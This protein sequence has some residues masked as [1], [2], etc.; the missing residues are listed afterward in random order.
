M[1]RGCRCLHRRRRRLLTL[2]PARPPRRTATKRAITATNASAT[3]RRPTARAAS[4]CR[5][6]SLAAG[7][8]SRRGTSTRAACGPTASRSAGGTT[9]TG[10]FSCFLELPVEA[11]NS[12]PN[13]Q[14]LTDNYRNENC[15]RLGNGETTDPLVVVTKPQKVLGAGKWSSICAKG[16]HSCGRKT[17]GSVWCWG[18]ND[19][20]GEF[21]CVPLVG[22][23][24]QETS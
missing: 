3:A 17:D 20:G 8:T 6:R 2:A 10:E 14:S 1:G 21:S 4:R 24:K 5:R 19:D 12:Q 13:N 7:A 23:S 15:R 16:S 22:Q 11:E 18:G 9:R